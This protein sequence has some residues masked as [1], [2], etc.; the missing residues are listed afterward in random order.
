[1][2]QFW[3]PWVSVVGISTIS[4]REIDWPADRVTGVCLHRAERPPTWHD[5]SCGAQLLTRAP[6]TGSTSESSGVPLHVP[7]PRLMNQIS[8]A[9]LP[10]GLQ[11]PD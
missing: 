2:T 8:K 3:A 5:H 6:P 10:P 11:C 4:F 1:M 7:G 9:Q